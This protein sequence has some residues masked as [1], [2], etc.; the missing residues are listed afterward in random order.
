LQHFLIKKS[1]EK[2]N[3]CKKKKPLQYLKKDKNKKN[4]RQEVQK[5]AAPKKIKKNSE[6]Q[7]SSESLC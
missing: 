2:G 5:K 7:A 6:V 1:I 4:K 3:R